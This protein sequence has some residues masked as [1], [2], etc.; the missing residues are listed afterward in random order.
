LSVVEQTDQEPEME[1]TPLL[2][3][4]ENRGVPG[5]FVEKIFLRVADGWGPDKKGLYYHMHGKWGSRDMFL[6]KYFWGER[7]GDRRHRRHRKCR[8]QALRQFPPQGLFRNVGF[9]R[10]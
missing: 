9:I 8:L 10:P 2:T 4:V 6:E 7:K 5:R 1:I 3:S